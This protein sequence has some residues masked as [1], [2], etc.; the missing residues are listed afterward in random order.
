[1]LGTRFM[2]LPP[3]LIPDCTEFDFQ[4]LSKQSDLFNMSD[5][6]AGGTS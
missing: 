1:M 2:D 5:R 6:E 3:S 4:L